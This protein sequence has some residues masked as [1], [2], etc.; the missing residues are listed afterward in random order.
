MLPKTPPS[1]AAG[2]TIPKRANFFINNPAS[3]PSPKAIII[4][5]K[6]IQSSD[7]LGM[8]ATYITIKKN[9]DAA[10]IPRENRVYS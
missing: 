3:V 6:M 8:T 5:T 4:M 1:Q 2:T 10:S 9:V 7:L